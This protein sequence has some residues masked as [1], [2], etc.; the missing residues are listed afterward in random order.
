MDG[1]YENII[2]KIEIKDAVVKAIFER[3]GICRGSGRD[4]NASQPNKLVIVV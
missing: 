1:R 3:K 2:G 4:V